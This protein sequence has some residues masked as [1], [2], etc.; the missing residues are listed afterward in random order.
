[1]HH[2]YFWKE[3]YG[4]DLNRIPVINNQPEQ[5]SIVQSDNFVYKFEVF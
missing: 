2:L 4:Q 5:W 3:I 1:M